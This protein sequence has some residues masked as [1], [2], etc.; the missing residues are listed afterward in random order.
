LPTY[1]Y[2]CARCS[3]TYE[4]REGFSAP[5]THKCQECGRGTAKRVLTAPRILFKG[6]GFY[7]TDSKSNSASVAD[8]PPSSSDDSSSKS[9]SA[10]AAKPESTP[11]SKSEAKS[12]SKSTA[13]TSAD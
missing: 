2:H 10:P 1:D 9:D 4:L 12:E 5:S 3:K 11:E 7:A 8:S 13:S 6:S